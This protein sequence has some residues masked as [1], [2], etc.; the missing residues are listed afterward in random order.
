[1]AQGWPRRGRGV[2]GVTSGERVEV[3]VNLVSPCTSGRRLVA[4]GRGL[5]RAFAGV[6]VRRKAAAFA[7]SFSFFSV[8]SVAALPRS[9]SV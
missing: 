1:M 4:D 6:D 3:R 7:S 8:L 2:G 9:I 5:S